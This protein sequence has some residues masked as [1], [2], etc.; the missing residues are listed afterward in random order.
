MA[1]IF[2]AKLT[3]KVPIQFLL[4]TFS[5]Q[6]YST[7]GKCKK[8]TVLNLHFGKTSVIKNL[9]W[10]DECPTRTSDN[11]ILIHEQE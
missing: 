2:I 10:L 9:D 7:T 11:I 3:F 8:K 5:T 6:A 1:A 4:G